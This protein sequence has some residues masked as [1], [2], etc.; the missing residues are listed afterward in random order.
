MPV[1]AWIFT[2]PSD[3][4]MLDVA[5]TPIWIFDVTQHCMWWANSEA[6]RFWRADRLADLTAR[7][8]STDSPSIRRRLQHIVSHTKPGQSVQETWTLYPANTPTTAFLTITPVRIGTPLH[9]DI[10]I[11]IRSLEQ[12]RYAAEDRRL[13]EATR[14]TSVLIS[15]VTL[16]GKLISLN[17]A[18]VRA[19]GGLPAKHTTRC[20]RCRRR[21]PSRPC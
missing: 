16:D 18:A 4:S 7:D 12:D 8:F 20:L 21:V 2:D 14:Y 9:D 1:D 15:H 6:L 13:L 19:Y 17:P 11:E 3:L 10:L 5:S